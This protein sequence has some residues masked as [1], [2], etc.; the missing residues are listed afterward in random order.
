MS[1]LIFIIVLV[2]L[3]VVHELGHFFVAKLSGMKVEE[4]G[5]GY[6]PRAA[7]FHYKGTDY[8]LNWLPFGGFVKILGEDGNEEGGRV[9]KNSF[10]AKPRALQ[11]LVLVAGIGMN[12]LFAWILV[13]AVLV[14][15]T[16][17]AL[18]VS[19]AA[20]A[21]DAHVEIT[22]VL[23]G[24]PAALGGVEV[25][26]QIRT[27]VQGT[28]AF[29]GYDAAAFSDF[30]AQDEKAAPLTFTVLR[31]T[32]EKTITLAPVS[33]LS[34]AAPDRKAVGVGV[35]TVGTL[36][37]SLLEAPIEGA[38]LTYEVT[39]ETAIALIHFFVGIFTFTADLSQVSGPIGIV[40]AVG[41][42]SNQGFA[43]LLL[44]MA[45]ISINLAL[46]N[47]IPVPALDGGRLLF[48]IIETILRKPIPK[49]IA[50][51]VN[52]AGFAFLILLMLTISAHDL[53]NLFS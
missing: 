22:N 34:A 26:D 52:A 29:S 11:A 33:G 6:P 28:S 45:V 24:S 44:I 14:I 32:E 40:G 38:K 42:A 4:F 18:S 12:L 41:S 27:V 13:S 10:V 25:G 1:I 31:G 8:T 15:G 35:A 39:K 49:R 17:R 37:V 51:A 7:G 50:N 21:P 23:P 20:S 9:P 43:P 53:F 5:I 19:E 2:A 3:I 36:Q 46:I 30:I 16:P 47:L 48:V